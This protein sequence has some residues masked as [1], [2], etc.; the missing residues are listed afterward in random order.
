MK[1]RVGQEARFRRLGVLGDWENS[2][3]TLKHEFEAKQLELFAD[4]L[5]KGYIY[6]GLKSVYWSTGC[7]T[8]LAE[9]EVEYVDNYKSPSIYVAFPVAKYS[10]GAKVLEKY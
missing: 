7:Q 3:M 10:D 2:Y 6:R 5:D 1:N 8:A 9:A 4:M